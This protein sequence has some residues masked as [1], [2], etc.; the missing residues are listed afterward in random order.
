M[1]TVRLPII[2]ITAAAFAPFGRIFAP[3]GGTSSGRCTRS[4]LLLGPQCAVTCVP[5]A[6]TEKK[7]CP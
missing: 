4:F 1:R 6:S 7:A 5:G 2:P 3:P